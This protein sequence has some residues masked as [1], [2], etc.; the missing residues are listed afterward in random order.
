MNF[1]SKKKERIIEGIILTVDLGFGMKYKDE[2]NM[3]LKMS[4]QQ[5]DG[6]ECV[7]LFHEDKIKPILRQFK[8]DYSEDV[9]LKSLI[10]HKVYLLASEQ[11]NGVPDAISKLPPSEYD[12]YEWIYNNNWD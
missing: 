6:Y 2:T 7:Q 12:G 11:T 8:K 4:I 3:F 1:K 10:H 5:F 9:S